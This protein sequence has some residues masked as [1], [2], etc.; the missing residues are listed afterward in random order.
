MWVPDEKHFIPSELLLIIYGPQHS[1]RMAPSDV[2]IQ[3]VTILIAADSGVQAESCSIERE[4]SEDRK[5]SERSSVLS[6]SVEVSIQHFPC[7]PICQQL[8][9]SVPNTD[10]VHSTATFR[11]LMDQTRM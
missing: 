4:A 11:T 7:N 1:R 2:T 8:Q 3:F 6:K 10:S 5:E 9:R